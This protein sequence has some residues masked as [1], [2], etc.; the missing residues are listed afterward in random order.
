MLACSYQ[1]FFS[2]GFAYKF[3]PDTIYIRSFTHKLST[4]ALS[5]YSEEPSS[6]TR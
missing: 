4:R 5:Y 6:S 1:D 3:D 2:V